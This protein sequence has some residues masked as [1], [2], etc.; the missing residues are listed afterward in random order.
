MI[1]KDYIL[2]LAERLGRFLARIIFLQETNQNEEALILIDDAFRQSL[3]LTSGLINS[4]P[5]ETLLAMLSPGNVLNVELCFFVAALLKA[6]GDIYANLDKQDDSYY[7][8]LKALNLFLELFLHGKNIDELD[9]FPNI[10]D[11]VQKLEEFELPLQ[12]NQKLFRYYEK[13]GRYAKAEDVLFDMLEG[14]APPRDMVTE[15]IDFYQRL[16]AKSDDELLLGNLS[17]EELAEGLRQV[18]EMQN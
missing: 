8:R 3:G 7:R 12:T 2:R 5:E 16:L 9:L 4:L 6:E 18:E 10:D 1:N 15:G 14:D 11:L 13:A 17:R